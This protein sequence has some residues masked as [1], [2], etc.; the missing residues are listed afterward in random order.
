M[1]LLSNMN[2]ISKKDSVPSTPH[3]AA[4]VFDSIYI[5]GDERSRT[6]PGHGYPAHSESVVKYIQF[7]N[8]AEMEKWVNEQET[9][10]YSRKDNYRIVEVKPLNVTLKA[11]VT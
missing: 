9:S 4:L 7:T 5:E 1:N 6:N 11:I 2:Y 8:R 3:Y 10:R